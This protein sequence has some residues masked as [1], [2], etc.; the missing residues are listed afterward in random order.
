MKIEDAV[1]N[2]GEL[3]FCSHNL[4]DHDYPEYARVT[5]GKQITS[6][7]CKSMDDKGFSHRLTL[8]SLILST[9]YPSIYIICA[10]T[11]IFRLFC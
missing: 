1:F 8:I 2:A 7:L 6:N 4:L 5:R 11:S 3:Q 10:T 9:S